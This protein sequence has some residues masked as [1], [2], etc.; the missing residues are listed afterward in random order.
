MSQLLKLSEHIQFLP[1]IHGSGS[2]AREVRHQLLSFPCDC[3]AVALPPEFK[4]TVEEGIRILPSI[5]NFSKHTGANTSNRR[6]EV[7]KA[8]VKSTNGIYITGPA[9]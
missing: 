4:Q 6:I 2:F 8:G 3:L 1:V 9:T 7:S 5:T